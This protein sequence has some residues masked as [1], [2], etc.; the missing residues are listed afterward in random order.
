MHWQAEHSARL[1]VLQGYLFLNWSDL[2]AY[3]FKGLKSV[4]V[5]VV[6]MVAGMQAWC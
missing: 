6:N 1:L 4:M 5:M 2:G 3:S